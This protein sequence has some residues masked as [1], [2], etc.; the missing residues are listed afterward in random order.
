MNQ[1]WLRV[2]IK[3]DRQNMTDEE[4]CWESESKVCSWG[5][6]FPLTLFISETTIKTIRI[7][8]GRQTRLNFIVTIASQVPYAGIK[9]K[10]TGEGDNGGKNIQLFQ[11]KK[12]I[13][14]RRQYLVL[15]KN[16][17]RC[18]WVWC[19]LIR[20]K[21]PCILITIANE[22]VWLINWETDDPSWLDF[23]CGYI[24]GRS[25]IGIL[26]S[27]SQQLERII[28]E[29]A[30]KEMTTDKPIISANIGRLFNLAVGML[31][32]SRN[33]QFFRFV[34]KWLEHCLHKIYDNC[35]SSSIVEFMPFIHFF[36]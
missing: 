19:Q 11:S 34:C 25:G 12:T 7:V 3:T 32:V 36:Q 17:N 2:T 28:A 22:Q 9:S 18:L 14:L 31:S 15:S 23:V 13:F 6:E 20:I 10:V 21:P 4:E 27:E 33:A 29:E 24:Q 35:L 16:K 1:G 8:N 5:Q 26:I 30:S